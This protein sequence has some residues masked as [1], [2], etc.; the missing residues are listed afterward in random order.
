M[1]QAA[2]ERTFFGIAARGI[3]PDLVDGAEAF[4][5]LLQSPGFAIFYP[6]DGQQYLLV[7]HF[8]DTVMH[9]LGEFFIVADAVRQFMCE[10]IGLF[11][12]GM[13]RRDHEAR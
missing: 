2:H 6:A 3:E 13:S 8:L 5:R 12:L 11:G 10:A 1:E 7:P 9:G 4:Q